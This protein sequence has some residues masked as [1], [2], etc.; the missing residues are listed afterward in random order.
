MNEFLDIVLR[1]LQ[2][3]V[4]LILGIY[5]YKLQK[6][7]YNVSAANNRTFIMSCLTSQFNNFATR[8]ANI[9]DRLRTLSN[10]YREI[11]KND[12]L[13]SHDSQYKACL[14]QQ[15]EVFFIRFI[16]NCESQ[17]HLLDGII[18]HGG[19]AGFEE[20]LEATE[21][22][23]KEV[24]LSRMTMVYDTNDIATASQLNSLKN[25]VNLS[26]EPTLSAEAIE[27]IGR[28]MVKP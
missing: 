3:G 2:I 22:M 26:K 21:K 6:E 24:D 12:T 13:N 15:I 4:T 16:L 14:E 5:A 27:R 7:S 19:H 17:K 28:M 20:I 18:R 10:Q 9:A 8:N 23:K 1:I 25:I 11:L